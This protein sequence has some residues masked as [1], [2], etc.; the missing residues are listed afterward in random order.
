MA[1]GRYF[2]GITQLRIIMYKDQLVKEVAKITKLQIKDAEAA[3]EAFISVV[4][5]S[6]KKGEEVKLIGFGSFKVKKTKPRT[7]RNPKTGAVLKIAAKKR[8]KFSPGAKL[9]DA[10]E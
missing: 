9:K 4:T 1:D 3:I 6:L 7:G 10:V 2:E 5:K 8:P